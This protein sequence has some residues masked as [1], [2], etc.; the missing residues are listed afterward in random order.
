[1]FPTICTIG[2]L[3]IFEYGVI[4]A[5]IAAIGSVALIIIACSKG[6]NKKAIIVVLFWVL[7]LAVLAII[8]LTISVTIHSYGLMLAIAVVICT[9]LLARDALKANIKVDIV[10]DF[11]FWSVIGGI[12]GAR[13]FYIY[14]NYPFFAKNP[15]EIIMIQNG[16]LAWQGG[17]VLGFITSVMFIKAKKLPVPKML[18]FFAPYLALGQSIGRIG[19]FL[20][21]CCFGREVDWGIF[22]PIHDATLHPTQLYLSGGY[23]L[24]FVMLKRYQR[25][26]ENSGFVFALYLILASSLRFGVEFFRADHEAFLLGLSIFQFVSI[27]GQCQGACHCLCLTI[28]R[29]S[30][31]AH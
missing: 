17:L 25:S 9:L 14:L 30:A 6:I 29:H 10:F 31:K 4:V 7:T 21:G 15:Q 22:F 27:G 12:I 16:G 1:M 19:C 2:P 18:D 5:L 20:N 26:S 13:L 8:P 23:F 24:M 11:V 3:S 28:E